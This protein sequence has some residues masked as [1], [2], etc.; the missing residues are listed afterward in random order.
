[1]TTASTWVNTR[2][3]FWLNICT[4]DIISFVSNI[5]VPITRNRFVGMVFDPQ[6]S[7]TILNYKSNNPI[8]CEELSNKWN[9][10]IFI[11]FSSIDF[12][13][14]WL[15]YIILIE[16]T[17]N[18]DSIFPVFFWNHINHHLNNA[19][20]TKEVIWKQKLSVVSNLLKHARKH[21]IQCIA[22]G[23]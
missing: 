23:N 20:F 12:L 10:R 3:F 18:L 22:L 2:N 4:F 15:R 6:S 21:A 1:M 5:V 14:F 17:N 8:R 13:I 11:L 7:Q 16:P 19:S 9:I